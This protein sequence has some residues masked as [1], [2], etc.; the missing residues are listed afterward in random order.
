MNSHG[1]RAES[2]SVSKTLRSARLICFIAWKAITCFEEWSLIACMAGMTILYT[3]SILSR[4]V[5]KMST[6]W[7]DEL[8]I[9]LFIWATFTG[10][11]LGVKRGAHLGVAVI[12][13]ALPR[14]A[15]KIM[16]V[17]VTLCCVFTC[18][19]LAWYGLQMVLLQFNMGQRSSQLGVPIFFVGLAVPAGMLLSLIRFIEGLARELRSE[20]GLSS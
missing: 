10:A 16:L 15:Q 19:V 11:S 13:N 17:V 7:A 12:Q 14:K 4:Y 20:G 3:L 6:P 18:A 2:Q 9:F 5:T 1:G 8:V